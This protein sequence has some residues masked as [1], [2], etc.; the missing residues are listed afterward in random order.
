MGMFFV[1]TYVF[2]PFIMAALIAKK[3]GRRH[4]A[5]VTAAQI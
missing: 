3:K 4:L 5:S 1:V 2:S